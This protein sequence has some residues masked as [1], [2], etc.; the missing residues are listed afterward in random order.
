[1]SGPLSG[2]R[3]FRVSGL[4]FLVAG[5]AVL[6]MLFS[7]WSYQGRFWGN[8]YPLMVPSSHVDE[9]LESFLS[10]ISRGEMVCES[11]SLLNY[12]GYGSSESVRVS[13]LDSGNFLYSDDPRLDPYMTGNLSY[14]NQGLYKI[15]YLP[16][17][18]SPFAYD[19]LLKKSPLTAGIDWILVD[20]S[21]P[22][23]S[24]L[25]FILT[26]GL[27]CIGSFR[28][29]LPATGFLLLGFFMFSSGDSHLLLL[30]LLAALPVRYMM[31]GANPVYWILFLL[32][33][34][35]GK[36]G[37]VIDMRYLTAFIALGCFSFGALMVIPPLKVFRYGRSLRA[38]GKGRIKSG[39]D[40]V[41]FEPVP[42]KEVARKVKKERKGNRLITSLVL[43]LS[44]VLLFASASE[45]Y[46]LPSGIPSAVSSGLSW[47][48]ESLIQAEDNPEFPGVRAYYRHRAYQDSFLYGGAY[49]LPLPGSTMSVEDFILEDGTVVNKPRIVFSFDH[50]WF[51]STLNEM[52]GSGPGRLMAGEEFIPG[53]VRKSSIISGNSMGILLFAGV[54]LLL[55]IFIRI[56]GMHPDRR[57]RSDRFSVKFV[58]R[59]KQQAA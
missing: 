3:A 45:E 13:E 44:L 20:S 18:R 4:F 15:F 43:I 7:L 36:L 16:A 19:Q 26:M 58:L 10:E 17:F 54:C 39:H 41:L 6:I 25:L 35:W 55:N 27:L 29:C 14:F 56:F 48:F 42:L 37:N 32:I 59:R 38:S 53:I 24:A 23:H 1:M 22:Y 34:V 52:S 5:S 11:N 57:I 12:N 50:G 33:P 21:F 2:K 8:W 51:N 46:L 9:E 31:D 47:D 30:L 28:F 40:H 49:E